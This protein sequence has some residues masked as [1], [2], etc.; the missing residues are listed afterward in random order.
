MN[1]PYSSEV[2]CRGDEGPSLVLVLVLS[3]CRALSPYDFLVL[4]PFR[5]DVRAR[6]PFPDHG[7]YP[8]IYPNQ[9]ADHQWDQDVAEEVEQQQYAP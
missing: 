2:H 1:H 8:P 9:E 5:F 4:S 6:V 3:P 7:L